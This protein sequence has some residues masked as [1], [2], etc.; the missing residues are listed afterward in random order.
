MRAIWR[1]GVDWVH[2]TQWPAVVSKVMNLGVYV[3]TERS[4]ATPWRLHSQFC[5]G[6]NE[7]GSHLLASHNTTQ[8]FERSHFSA[9]RA[10]MC[11][12]GK[13]NSRPAV[14]CFREIEQVA[15]L[16]IMTSC[17]LVGEYRRF[18]GNRVPHYS[19]EDGDTMFIRNSD[20]HV[21]QTALCHNP[22]HRIV[23]VLTSVLVQD[24][25]LGS[26][27]LQPCLYSPWYPFPCQH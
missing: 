7:G 21:H 5:L 12:L 9:I 3:T 15:V 26:L 24:R 22:Q 10:V 14:T 18:G 16:W 6:A 20:I 8:T 2:V 4:M 27:L 25:T 23:S 13:H 19:P 11:S 17:S 1:E